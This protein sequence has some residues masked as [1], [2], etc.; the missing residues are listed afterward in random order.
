MKATARAVEREERELEAELATL[1]EDK[2]K[3]DGPRNAAIFIG[4][5]ALGLVL[6]VVLLLILTA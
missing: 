2:I 6:D 4:V 1:I 3:E 5:I